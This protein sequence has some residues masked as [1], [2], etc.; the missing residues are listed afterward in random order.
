MAFRL[1]FEL[2]QIRRK[3]DFSNSSTGCGN[4]FIKAGRHDGWK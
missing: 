2:A 1:A 4:D 3:L